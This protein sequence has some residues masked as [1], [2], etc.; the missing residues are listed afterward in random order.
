LNDVE[1]RSSLYFVFF[2]RSYTDR[3]CHK[4]KL[5]TDLFISLTHTVRVVRPIRDS[6]SRLA[7]HE[8]LLTALIDSLRVVF[9]EA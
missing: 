6:Q 4:M 1:R 7:S 2:H 9:Q 8:S 5:L 3:L